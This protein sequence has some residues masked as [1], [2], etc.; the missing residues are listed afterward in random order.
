LIERPNA[1]GLIGGGKKCPLV[2]E[3]DPSTYENGIEY[4]LTKIKRPWTY[5]RVERMN[6]ALKEAAVKRHRHDSR[7]R[8]MA[9]PEDFANACHYARRPKTLGGL[10]PYAF[11]GKKRIPEPKRFTLNSIHQMTGPNS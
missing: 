4:R 2:E 1:R 8:F 11:I 5:A 6:R 7:R 3:C 9:R 10:A